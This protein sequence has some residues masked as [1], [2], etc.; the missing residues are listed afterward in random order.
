MNG[1]NIVDV[2][3]LAELLKNFSI[4]GEEACEDFIEFDVYR[5]LSVTF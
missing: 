3:E 2:P 1:P 4:V 5:Y